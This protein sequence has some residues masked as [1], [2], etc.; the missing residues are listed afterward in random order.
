MTVMNPIFRPIVTALSLL[1]TE[2]AVFVASAPAVRIVLDP[3]KTLADRII[4]GCAIFVAS[5]GA[6]HL[7][8]SRSIL[9]SVDNP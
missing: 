6:F 1:A 8:M 9:P 2:A 4:A 5:A 7:S 3:S